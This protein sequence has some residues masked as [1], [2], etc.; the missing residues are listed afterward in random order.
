MKEK[1]VPIAKVYEALS[2]VGD[3]RVRMREPGKAVVTSSDSAKTYETEWSDD[4]RV[5][6]SNDN[7][8]YWQGYA[9]YP[10]IAVLIKLG[11][12]KADPNICAALSGINWKQLNKRKKGDYAAAIAEVLKG[13]SVEGISADA[14]EQE[15]ERIHQALVGLGIQTRRSLKSPPK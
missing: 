1:S 2:A 3:G 14:V 13:L 15:A 7:A 4:G 6:R 9:G 11:R 5:W 10:I 8:S 12:L